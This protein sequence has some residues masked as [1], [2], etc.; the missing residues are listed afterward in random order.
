M[1]HE[2]QQIRRD[3]ERYWEEQ[4]TL[5]ETAAQRND[6]H[7][8]YNLLHRAK[9][10]PRQKSSLVK[11]SAGVVLTTEEDCIHRWKE[12]F[13][14]LLSHPP[15][16][17]DISLT[18]EAN[19][20]RATNPDCDIIPV[21]LNEVKAALKKLKNSKAPGICS[22]TAEMLKTGGDILFLIPVFRSKRRPPQAGLMPSRSKIDHISAIRLLIEKVRE[23]RKDRNLYIGSID[24]KAAFDTVDH[25]SLW[26]I[27]K[28]LGAPPK[29][30][31]LFQL[32]YSDAE[33]CVP[34]NGKESEWF[35]INSGVRQDF[36]QPH[37]RS[38][39]GDNQQKHS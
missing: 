3:H 28:T 20:A 32:L 13:S 17:E 27:L 38:F 23:F 29:I 7:Q 34:I 14:Q 21:S 9:A 8:L 24:L 31:S 5:L 33:S 16:P 19:T 4:A 25:P 6:Q 22:I 2:M 10:G 12:H 11:G 26:K 1:V 15:V 37:Q 30:I 39:R 35:T 36:L 18:Q